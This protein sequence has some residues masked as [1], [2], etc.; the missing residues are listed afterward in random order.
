LWKFVNWERSSPNNILTGNIHLRVG[1]EIVT[2]PSR[3][4]NILVF[5]KTFIETVSKLILIIILH[6]QIITMSVKDSLVLLEITETEFIKI[7]QRMMNKN[8]AGLDDV[9]TY[10]LKEFI[11]HIIKL[12][13][14]L[15]NASIRE[16]IFPSKL[17]KSDV[18]LMYKNG[19]KEG[20]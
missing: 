20:N 1:N 2:I 12:L 19:A 17:K 9:S 8:S 3:T 13:L 5:N 4:C 6:K 11:P 7:I 15:V 16:G 10:L 14:E 18:K